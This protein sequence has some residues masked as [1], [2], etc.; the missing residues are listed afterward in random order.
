[1]A[2]APIFWHG[3]PLTGNTRH[4]VS[5]LG[6]MIL[7]VEEQEAAAPGVF[8]PPRWRDAI[9]RDLLDLRFYGSAPPSGGSVVA[10]GPQS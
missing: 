9:E 1:M 2:R 5:L 10:K 8:K 3:Q 4:R 6:K 7:Q